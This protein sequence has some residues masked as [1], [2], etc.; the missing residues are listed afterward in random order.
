MDS[1]DIQAIAARDQLWASLRVLVPEIAPLAE[2]Q[3]TES[4]RERD[5]IQLLA[6]ITLAELQFRADLAEPE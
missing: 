5:I 3:F 4:P 1:E 2:G 6:R